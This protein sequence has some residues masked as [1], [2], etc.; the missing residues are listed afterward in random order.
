[1]SGNLEEASL[2][3]TAW[4]TGLGRGYW[5]VV[6]QRDGDDD[7]DDEEDDGDYG[8]SDDDNDVESK[9]GKVRLHTD[10]CVCAR[11]F[12]LVASFITALIEAVRQWGCVQCLT[13][14][15]TGARSSFVSVR[16]AP[17]E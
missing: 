3:R 14:P 7:D 5:P 4:R 8:G 17:G 11:I 10:V 16:R 2:D 9:H 13:K 6:R 15:I 12:F 1:M